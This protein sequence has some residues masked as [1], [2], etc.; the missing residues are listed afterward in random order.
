MPAEPGTYRR[1]D[2]TT[3]AK[4]RAEAVELRFNGWTR[5][6]D[7]KPEAAQPDTTAKPQ[8]DATKRADDSKPEA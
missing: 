1:G 2:D 5:V 7:T 4:T 6:P 3:T 8:S